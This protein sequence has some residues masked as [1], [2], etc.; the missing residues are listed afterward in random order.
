MSIL[1]IGIILLEIILFCIIL[2]ITHLLFNF[3]AIHRFGKR[4][5]ISTSILINRTDSPPTQY[6][7]ISNVIIIDPIGFNFGLQLF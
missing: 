2:Y 5:L 3:T 1:N 4:V 6:R 7:N